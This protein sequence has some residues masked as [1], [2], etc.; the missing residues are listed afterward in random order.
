LSAGDHDRF[1]DR[2]R[3]TQLSFGDDPWGAVSRAETLVEDV[4]RARGYPAGD[5]DQ[6]AADISVD[7]PRSV[8][9]YREARGLA[10]ASQR[11]MPRIEDLRR[12]TIYFKEMF[13]ELLETAQRGTVELRR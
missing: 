6:R 12:A 1:A 13:E 2:W 4:M 8:E 5:F 10:V 9:N 3:K 7:H 11:G